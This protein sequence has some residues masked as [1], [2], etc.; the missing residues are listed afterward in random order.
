ME[1]DMFEKFAAFMDANRGKRKFMQSVDLAVNF[2][3]VDFSKQDNRLNLEIML[4]NGKGRESKIMIFSDDKNINSKALQYGAKI[5]PGSEIPS[6]TNDKAR[7]NE[8]I[9]YELAAE[10]RLMPAIAKS[11]GQFLG[12]RNKMPKPL[13]GNFDSII[14]SMGKLVYV[15][16]KGKYLPT[17]H[18]VVGNEKMSNDN[19]AANIDEVL[20][21]IAKKVGKQ[22]L[23]S[24][25][26][27]LTMSEPFRLI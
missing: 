20:S 9:H 4:P 8:L 14:G 27:K 24:A 5:V 26:V 22:N 3:N 15:R 19:I 17:V 7:I 10:P 11:L 2:A 12:P 25:Y 16:N 18:C 6:I 21:A 23:K 13:V 1:K